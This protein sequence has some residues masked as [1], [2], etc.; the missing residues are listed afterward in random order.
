LAVAMEDGFSLWDLTTR[1]ELA[2]VE[3][4]PIFSLR[5]DWESGVVMTIGADGLGRWPVGPMETGSIRIGIP[6][7]VSI[8][9]APAAGSIAASAPYVAILQPGSARIVDF[10]GAERTSLKRSDKHEYVKLSP[11]GQS[12]ATYSWDTSTTNVW[13]ARTGELRREV[14]TSWTDVVEFT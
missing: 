5:F 8:Q 11:D 7:I 12:V 9:P 13:D 10:D 6:E 4:G 14:E 1:R 2:H 3:A